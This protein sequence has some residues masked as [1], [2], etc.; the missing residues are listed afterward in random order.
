MRAGTGERA[1][2]AE[3]SEFVRFFPDFV[4]AVRDFTLELRADE[5]PISEDEYLERALMLKPGYG[6]QVVVYNTTRQCI[7]NY[8]PTRKCF[9]FPPPVGA[10]QRGRPEELPEAALQ[11]GFLEQVERFCQ[12]VLV[13]SRPKQL[14]DG[15]ELNG[16]FGTVVTSYLETI[17]SGRVP[18]LEGT[19]VALAASEN[20]AAA[21]EALVEYRRGMQDV[22]LPAEQH[23]LSE[24]HNRWL[25]QALAVFHHRAFRDRDQQQQLK[26]MVCGSQNEEASRTRCW[27]LLAELARPLEANLAQGA[28]AQPGGYHAYQADRQRLVDA[29]REAP[30]KG[31]KAEEMLDKFL[32][33]PPGADSQK[34][35]NKQLEAQLADQE[36]SYQ[37]SLRMMEDKMQAEALKAQEEIKR[38][39][40]AKMQEQER[41]LKQGF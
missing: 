5:R 12:H 24:A 21:A 1:G 25:Q 28:Y 26:L 9:V 30:N 32:E 22:V 38:A 2:E 18:C 11:P 31:T 19:M 41:L 13:A 27:E 39:M 16:P 35:Q 34:E 14:Q 33:G 15:V 8:F 36:R 10:E 3:D 40:E 4:W 20:A 6:R 23:E 7:R 29:Y 17:S 37:K